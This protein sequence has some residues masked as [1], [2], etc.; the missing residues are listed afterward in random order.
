MNLPDLPKGYYYKFLL[1]GLGGYHSKVAI[2]RKRRFWFDQ[3][4]ATDYTELLQKYPGVPGPLH[5]A[6]EVLKR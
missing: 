3:K 2:M 1:S 6:A 4:V 5:A